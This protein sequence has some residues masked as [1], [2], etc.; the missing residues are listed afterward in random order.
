MEEDGLKKS[1]E[2]ALETGK[3]P[4]TGETKRPLVPSKYLAE[5]GITAGG[6]ISRG[7]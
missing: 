5:L 6:G 2:Y 7:N 1:G 4:K 3:A